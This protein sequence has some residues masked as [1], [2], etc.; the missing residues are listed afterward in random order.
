MPAHLSISSAS[1]GDST[2]ER[3]DMAKDRVRCVPTMSWVLVTDLVLAI[4]VPAIPALSEVEI[5][6]LVATHL[7]RYS[8][9]MVWDV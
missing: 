3:I 9:V 6:T 5:A 1:S 8:Q 7:R 2:P 4:V